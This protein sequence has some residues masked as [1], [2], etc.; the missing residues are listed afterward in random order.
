MT[1]MCHVINDV[2]VHVFLCV[3]D[4]SHVSRLCAL[5]KGITLFLCVI[6]VSHV[7]M[8]S[9]CLTQRDNIVFVV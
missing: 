4:V 6:D 2:Y 3:I 5:L 1:P 8:T 7:S 9:M